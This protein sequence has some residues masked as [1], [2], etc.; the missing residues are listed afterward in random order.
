MRKFKIKLEE[1]VATFRTYPKNETIRVVSHLDADGICSAALVLNMLK[2][3][4]YKYSL[5]IVRQL[6][7]DVLE[8]L[9]NEDYNYFIF[10]DLGS[11]QYDLIKKYLGSKKILILD[12]HS[13]NQDIMDTIP[14]N[15]TMVNPHL[16]GIDGS[17]DIS[18]SGVVYL[19][20]VTLNKKNKNMA[21]IAII[22]A[23]GD[24]QEKNGFT[25]I[26][27]DIL[28]DAIDKNKIKVEQS[29]KWFGIETKPL[30][31]LL[32]YGSGIDIPN[33]T[34]SESNVIQFLKN[35]KIEPKLGNK[36][37]TYSELDEKQKKNLTSAII[38][39]RAGKK[40]PEDILGKRYLLVKE[41]PGTPFRDA[42]EF[43]TL[44][45][46]CG[47]MNKASHGI[48]A[49]LNDK[50]S[51]RK[52]L[53]T[54]SKYRREIGTALR[55]YESNSNV[56]KGEKYII[57][58][59]KDEVLSTVIGT[60]ASII[61][62][63]NDLA[64][65]TLILSLAHEPKGITKVSLRIAGENQELDLREVINSIIKKTNSGESGGHKNAA[66]AI[67][68]TENENNFIKEAVK[69]FEKI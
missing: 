40:K 63:S 5:S 62:K 69:I 8:D 24:I 49:C 50:I 21:H 48:G 39:K 36:W 25:G 60:L 67:I 51:K 65:G 43:S 41:E 33:I 17:Q 15:I 29:L 53:D 68:K 14:K 58:N 32:L 20:S 26:N 19:F 31:K 30:Y 23:I 11:G 55:W 64:E 44:L 38:M 34:G 1:A 27:N 16:C 2:N 61:S 37:I 10:S 18:G 47:R 56:I 54:L 66:G 59:A 13:F 7:E 12:H 52:A 46:A 45:N 22:G 3:E 28:K 9:K 35:I 4:N 57:L 42:K 6:S